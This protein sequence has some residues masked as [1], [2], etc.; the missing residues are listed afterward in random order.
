MKRNLKIIGCLGLIVAVLALPVA[1]SAP[2]PAP[3]WRAAVAGTPWVKR[4]VCLWTGAEQD[5]SA[6]PLSPRLEA[7]FK[8]IERG[9]LFDVFH[10]GGPIMWPLLGAALLSLITVLERAGF[11]ALEHLRRNEREKQ[12]F[13]QALREGDIEAAGVI[14]R[15]SRY[16]VVR[17]LG[18]ALAHRGPALEGAVTY[19]T[20][21][22][23]QRY[24]RGVSV[25][26]TVI[27][28]APLLGLLGTV[29]G[30][31][32]SFS[33]IGGDLGAPGAITGGIAEALIATAFGLGIAITS[34]IPFNLIN[35][36]VETATQE[37]DEAANALM[38]L[39]AAHGVAPAKGG[40]GC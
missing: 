35:Q 39:F 38:M 14:G 22:E 34:L 21:Q 40:A 5:D 37:I 15:Q 3:G 29:T 30:M 33:L 17:V 25:L 26:D 1:A 13:M 8:V 2:E 20:E 6:P 18:Y 24:R 23:L 7:F 28:L 31:M 4:L 11:F 36:R 9:N 27:T 19:A 32:A 12:K 10:Q 16:F